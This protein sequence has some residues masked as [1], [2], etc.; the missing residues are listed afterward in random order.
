MAD[1][2]LPSRTPGENRFRRNEEEDV[3]QPVLE[4]RNR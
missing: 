1:G 2:R 3:G 4:V